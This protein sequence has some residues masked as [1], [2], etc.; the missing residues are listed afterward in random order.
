ME[1]MYSQRQMLM[2]LNFN[3]LQHFHRKSGSKKNHLY[4]Y[5]AEDTIYVIMQNQRTQF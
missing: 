4:G 5:K 3:S 2:E 1:V